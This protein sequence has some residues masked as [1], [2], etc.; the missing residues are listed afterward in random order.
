MLLLPALDYPI[1]RQAVWVARRKRFL[2]QRTFEQFTTRLF[3]RL[4]LANDRGLA[5]AGHRS[6]GWPKL[7][8]I[9]AVA[10]ARFNL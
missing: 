6:P 9:Q 2:Q 4:R 10:L 1:G 8:A 7:L 5:S 3:P